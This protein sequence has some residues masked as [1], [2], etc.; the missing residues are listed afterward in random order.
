MADVVIW[1]A[2]V[3][4]LAVATVLTVHA[5]AGNRFALVVLTLWAVLGVGLILNNAAAA[6]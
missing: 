5:G 6:T 2:I 1:G 3:A 4:Y